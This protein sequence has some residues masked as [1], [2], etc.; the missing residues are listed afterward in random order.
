MGKKLKRKDL[1]KLIGETVEVTIVGTLER[2]D[3]GWGMDGV[4]DYRIDYSGDADPVVIA[5]VS[6]TD[7]GGPTTFT[8][9]R[10]VKKIKKV[11][12]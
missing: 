4:P 5:D 3:Y 7:I 11:D 9:L 2:H 1:E 10:G 6:R 12:K 8:V